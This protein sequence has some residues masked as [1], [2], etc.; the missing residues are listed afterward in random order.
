MS[1]TRYVVV[2]IV[3]IKSVDG[4]CVFQRLLNVSFELLCE[5]MYILP[6]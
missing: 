4:K 6:S 3:T 1:C 5:A 2:S